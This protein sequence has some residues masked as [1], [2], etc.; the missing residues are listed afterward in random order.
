MIQSFTEAGV[1]V[2]FVISDIDGL[3]CADFESKAEGVVI[4]I[5]RRKGR[6]FP[7]EFVGKVFDASAFFSPHAIPADRYLESFSKHR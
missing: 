2:R 4:E 1:S 3:I 6:I 7:E 5:R